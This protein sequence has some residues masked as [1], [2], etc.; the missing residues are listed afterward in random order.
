MLFQRDQKCF[1]KTLE[2]NRTHEGNVPEIDKF[3]YF[4]GGIWGQQEQT[5]NMPWTEEVKRQLVQK[6]SLVNEFEIKSKN[7]HKEVAKRKS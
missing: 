2:G 6:V 1:F 3:A 4:W 5:P 7:L